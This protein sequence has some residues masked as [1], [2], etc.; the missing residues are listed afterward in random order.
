MS[1]RT[2]KPDL[3]P[4][5][6]HKRA[7]ASDHRSVVRA[8]LMDEPLPSEVLMDEPLP[9]E[10]QGLSREDESRNFNDDRS[11]TETSG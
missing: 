1:T 5:E 9:P 3:G 2:E 6:R 7:G 4:L 11:P 8:L 10:E